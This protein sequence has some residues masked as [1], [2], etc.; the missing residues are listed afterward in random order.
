MG[1][2][3]GLAL[4]A[5]DRARMSVARDPGLPAGRSYRSVIASPIVLVM[6]LVR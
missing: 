2:L 1:E 4:P 5:W 3:R 6:G